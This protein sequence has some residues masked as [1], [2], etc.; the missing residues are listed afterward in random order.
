VTD[1][2]KRRENEV[3][4]NTGLKSNP[5][6]EGIILMDPVLSGCLRETL[7]ARKYGTAKCCLR[8]VQHNYPEADG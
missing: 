3:I 6:T 1:K 7:S 8:E 5:T 4:Q 2:V